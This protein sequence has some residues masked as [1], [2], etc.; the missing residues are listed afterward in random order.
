MKRNKILF[1]SILVLIAGLV[2]IGII[3][4]LLGYKMSKVVVPVIT[5]QN[6]KKHVHYEEKF[7]QKHVDNHFEEEIIEKSNVDEL[8]AE[9]ANED[10]M[11][12]FDEEIA[13]ERMNQHEMLAVE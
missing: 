2:V 7:L 8:E 5:L 12:D 3:L 9:K 11:L 1:L 13:I 6:K 10:E 4:Y